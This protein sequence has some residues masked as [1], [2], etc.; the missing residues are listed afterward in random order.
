MRFRIDPQERVHPL[1]GQFDFDQVVAFGASRSVLLEYG[2]WAVAEA[3][4]LLQ[5]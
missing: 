4:D 1:I 5:N 3:V 2:F